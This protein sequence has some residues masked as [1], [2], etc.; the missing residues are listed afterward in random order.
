MIKYVN[1]TAQIR[2][3]NDFE[4][5]TKMLVALGLRSAEVEDNPEVILQPFFPSS[6]ALEVVYRKKPYN[7]ADLELVVSDPDSAIEIVKKMGLVIAEDQTV[8]E[9]G[10]V[11]R[12]FRVQLPGGTSIF[13]TGVRAT[14]GTEPDHAGIEGNLSARGKRFAI[15]VSRFNS[16]IT[17]RL[18]AGTI[19]GLVRCG[20]AGRKDYEIVRVPGAFEVPSAARTLAETKKY[21]AIIC[22]G[23]LLRGDTAHY[24]VIV[25]EVT[26]GIGQSAQETGVPHAFGVLTCET[27]E[28]AI[29]R[30]GL[31][32]GNKGFEAALAAVEMANLRKAVAGRSSLVVGKGART[33]AA[34]SQ[35]SAL[36]K[37]RQSRRPS[38]AKKRS[39]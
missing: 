29:D 26:R 27:L 11:L 30:A 34:G 12:D 1:L 16:F 23:C 35:S 33:K 20:V 25:N 19:D 5:L 10:H 31:K 13:L 6:A 36:S 9:Q 8:P 4:L 28:Q 37:N 15:V 32:M 22:L 17:E 18:L 14:A 7:H 24:D 39:R 3:K 38:R 21:D 2:D